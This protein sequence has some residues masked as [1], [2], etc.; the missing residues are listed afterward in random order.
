MDTVISGKQSDCSSAKACLAQCG[1]CHGTSGAFRKTLK[2]QW[3]HA[4]CAEVLIY[5]FSL[6]SCFH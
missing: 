2:G 5:L 6:Y 4:F 1:L 3:V